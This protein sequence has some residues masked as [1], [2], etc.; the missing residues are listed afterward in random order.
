MSALHPQ[1]G[2]QHAQAAIDCILRI[3]SAPRDV[4]IKE[5]RDMGRRFPGVGWADLADEY[6]AAIE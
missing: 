4:K 1:Y 5:C 2:R 6:E 3:L